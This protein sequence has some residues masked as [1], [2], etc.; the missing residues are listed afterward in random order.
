MPHPG[1]TVRLF[2]LA[3]GRA[4]HQHVARS[5]SATAPLNV[6]LRQ[7]SHYFEPLSA[8]C[9]I[10]SSEPPSSKRVYKPKTA[11][12][13]ILKRFAS[14]EAGSDTP[15][16]IRGPPSQPAKDYGQSDYKYVKVDITQLGDDRG[17]QAVISIRNPA[18]L[19]ILTAET[20][21]ELTRAIETLKTYARPRVVIF[22]G[23][24]EPPHTAAFCAGANIREME[25]ISTPEQA[26]EFITRLKDLCYLIYLWQAVTI[27]RID[28]LC[29]GAGLELAACCDFRYGT[30]RSTFSMREVAVGIPSVIQ[31]RLL[32]N[33]MGWQAAKRMVLLGKVMEADEAQRSSLL[34]GEFSTAEEMDAHIQEDLEL[35]GSYSQEAVR[36]QKELNLYWE[37]H[38]L[39]AGIEKGV[40]VFADT[41]ADGGTQPK[42][43]MR[44]WMGRKRDSRSG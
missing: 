42:R 28:G 6:S 17:R 2:S 20:I 40:D 1:H 5:S 23:Q 38:G 13:T 11:H 19:N 9:Q 34:D 27:A 39:G 21:D 35:V 33:I 12:S 10:F 3:R 32:A 14:K 15:I 4:T 16:V 37:S 18:K 43:Y 31:A 22:T 30:Q 7:I 36:A 8:S 41:W 44:A 29:F 24:T 26:R 25:S